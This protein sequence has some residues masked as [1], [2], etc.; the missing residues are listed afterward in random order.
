MARMSLSSNSG[1]LINKPSLFQTPIA[2]PSG[3]ERVIIL[4]PHQDDESLGCGGRTIQ[5]KQA[6]AEVTVVYTSDGRL[7]NSQ[8][9]Q[10]D[11]VVRMRKA[12]AIQ[13][14]SVLGIAEKDVIFLPFQDG[15]LPNVAEALT[16]R[17][18]EIFEA[19]NP[20]ELYFPYLRDFHSDHIATSQAVRGAI[21]IQNRP[22]T[23]FEYL[24]WGIYHWPWV[25]IPRTGPQKSLVLKNTL[26]EIF[27]WRVRWAYRNAVFAEISEVKEKKLNAL[28]QHKSQVSRLV[29]D[30]S[31]LTL[32][33][34]A[35][36]SWARQFQTDYEVFKK[37]DF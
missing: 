15:N 13:A 32:S 24:V 29:N 1:A 4:A 20:T 22:V 19:L 17:L 3:C 23:G 14:C 10:E 5:L 7:A 18:S 21:K 8:F 25:T 11:E 34:V 35:E 26:R 30:P 16:L 27:G 36:G 9:M 33:D 31:W 12:E 2:G 37:T 28:M 6:G